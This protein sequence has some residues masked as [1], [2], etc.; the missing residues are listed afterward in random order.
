ML[1]EVFAVPI[2]IAGYWSKLNA[3]RVV[4]TAK[5]ESLRVKSR[6]T[7]QTVADEMMHGPWSPYLCR[8]YGEASTL[9]VWTGTNA[10]LN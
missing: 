9:S 4:K 6:V 5:L 8:Q 1:V 2:L 10:I 3:L 7:R